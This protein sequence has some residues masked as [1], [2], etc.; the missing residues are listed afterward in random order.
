MAVP[1]S[2]TLIHF[3]QRLSVRIGRFQ[4][5]FQ[6]EKCAAL[7]PT[8]LYIEAMSAHFSRSGGGGVAEICIKQVLYTSDARCWLADPWLINK[9]QF[10][11]E[12]AK[13]IKPPKHVS[14]FIVKIFTP[15][16]YQ[17]RKHRKNFVYMKGQGMSREIWQRAQ[18]VDTRILWASSMALWQYQAEAKRVLGSFFKRWLKHNFRSHL[19]VRR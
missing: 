17:L 14:Y 9:Y 4:M 8:N 1:M 18:Y 19:R 16:R 10:T 12:K 3:F 11:L 6:K 15:R 5:I 7:L 13:L 2:I